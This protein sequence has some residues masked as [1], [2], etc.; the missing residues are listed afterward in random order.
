MVPYEVSQEE[1]SS[2]KGTV[3]YLDPCYLQ[4]GNYIKAYDVFSFGVVAL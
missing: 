4:T 1:A 3:H 2:L